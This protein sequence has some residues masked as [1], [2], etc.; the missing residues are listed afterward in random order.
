[1][2][3]GVRTGRSNSWLI[4]ALASAAASASL[5]LS[6][7]LA[8]LFLVP[9]QFAFGRLGRRGGWLATGAAVL[10]ILPAELLRAVQ[11]GSS[12]LPLDLAALLAFP[13]AAIAA[14]LLFNAGFASAFRPGYR[15]LGLGLL[16]GALA[17]PAVASL[18]GDEELKGLLR[19]SVSRVLGRFTQAMGAAGQAA[20][21]ALPA[22]AQGYDAAALAAGLDPAEMVD[23]TLSVFASCYAALLCLL[24]GGSW[25]L[26]NRLAGEGSEGRRLAPPLNELRAPEALVWPFLAGLGFLLLVLFFKAGPLV[27]AIA[28][29]LVLAMSLVYAAQG[30]GIV[31]HAL[32]RLHV[33]GGFRIAFAALALLSATLSPVG[34]ALLAILPLLGLTELWIPYRNSKGVGA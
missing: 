3:D 22:P 17:A 27:R 33:P 18:L 14:L 24:L 29:N 30:A 16:L 19:D 11:G 28:W 23:S 1:M 25:W 31:S 21:G 13:L 10:L 26:G 15:M 6:V 34:A 32:R 8:P 9:L 20:G 12:S 2:I 4:A 7:I 5:W